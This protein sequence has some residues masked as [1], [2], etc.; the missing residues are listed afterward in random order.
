MAGRQQPARVLVVDSGET[1]GATQA[2]DAR[3]SMVLAVLGGEPPERVARRWSVDAV[4]VERWV[5]SFVA[6]GTAAVTNRPGPDDARRRD[7]FLAAFAHELRTP[8]TVAQG[9]ALLLADGDVPEEQ[10]PTSVARMYDALSRLV[11]RTDDVELMATASMGRLEVVPRPV[12]VQTLLSTLPGSPTAATG[13]EIVVHADVKLFARALADLWETARRPP[14]P[15]DL[16]IEATQTGPWHEFRIIRTGTPIEPA[17]LHALF[18]PFELNDDATGVTIGLSLARALT[19]AH[20]GILGADESPHSTE[21]W[22]RLPMQPT[23][24]V[25]PQRPVGFGR[26]TGGS[27]D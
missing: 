27:T 22:V 8:L 17:V 5:H 25:P 1:E 14:A 2:P 24:A 3:V 13:G 19:A 26:V 18:D 21:I 10:V 4:Q 23:A 6:G 7:R 9:W 11:S 12:S 15:D 16:R 20:G